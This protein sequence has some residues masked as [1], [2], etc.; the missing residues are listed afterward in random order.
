MLEVALALLAV[1]FVA[2]CIFLIGYM[3]W[4]YGSLEKLGIPVVKPHFLLGSL[5]NRHLIIDHEND[6]KLFKK[7]GEIFGVR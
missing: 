4:N 3:R 2:I 6:Y 5:P 1:S 7:Y